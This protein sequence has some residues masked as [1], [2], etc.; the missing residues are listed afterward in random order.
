MKVVIA[1]HA[2]VC[3]GVERALRLAGEA[4]E[5]GGDV[6]TLGPLIHNPQAVQ[7]L[8]GRGIKI[9]DDL[10]EVSGG[11][12]IIRSHGVVPEII[13]DARKRGLN[14]VDATCPFVTAAHECAEHLV[15]DGYRLIIMGEADHP[16]V[17]GILAH[18]KEDA[19]VIQ[20]LEDLPASLGTKRIG[21]VVQTT[22]S[23]Q[24]LR[25]VVDALLP[26]TR[27]LKVC[28]TICS[29]TAKRQEA[30]FDLARSVDVVVVVGGYNS[31]NTTR[32]AEICSGENNRAY[33][34]ETADELQS[35]WFE[36]ARVVGV[37]GGAST[38]HEQMRS[39]VEAIKNIRSVDDD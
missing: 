25:E 12:L 8:R 3:Y 38:P 2:G 9:A 15:A 27:E 1:K 10:D 11:T 31:G 7:E 22:Q 14:V 28:N 36:G 16:E 35:E 13:E 37:S 30:A 29:A 24:R 17:E 26:R 4:A 20:S 6:H 19:L 23:L 32:L 18:A 33:H 21:L 34:V 39:V 5:S